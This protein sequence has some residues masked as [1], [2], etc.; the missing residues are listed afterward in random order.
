M[1]IIKVRDKE[2]GQWVGIPALAGSKGERGLKGDKGDS[3][4]L[5]E[6]DKQEIANLVYAMMTN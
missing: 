1:D 2:T 5:T 6:S 4:I 3:Y